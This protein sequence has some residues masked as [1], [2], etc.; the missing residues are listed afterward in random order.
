MSAP[1]RIDARNPPAFPFVVVDDDWTAF[2][3]GIS[4]RTYLIGKALEGSAVR[5]R[6]LAGCEYDK[7]VAAAEAIADRAVARIVNY[8]ET[9]T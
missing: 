5:M 1:P 4:L 6:G 7:V 2:H 3:C 8:E 9:G